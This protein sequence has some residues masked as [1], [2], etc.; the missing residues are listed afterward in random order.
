[1]KQDLQAMPDT[2]MPARA[3]R[4][5]K[6]ELLF[7]EEKFHAREIGKYEYLTDKHEFNKIILEYSNLISNS[8]ISRIEILP[9]AVLFTF[10]PL[11]IQ[12]EADGGARSAPFEILNF[13]SYEP[14][15]EAM[16]YTLIQSG[17]TILDVGAHIGWYA[18]NFAKRFPESKVYTF[19]PVGLTFEF[20]KR[21][22]ERNHLSNVVCL[23]FGLSSVEEEREFYYYKGGSALASIE[24]LISHQ[25][26]KKVKCQLKP[27]DAL[28]IELE[29]NAVNFIKCDVEGAELFMLQGARNTINEFQPIILIELYEEWCNKCG[30]SSK[31]VMDFLTS[32][33]YS[34]FQACD[35]KLHKISTTEFTNT[36]RYNYFFM[37]NKNHRNLIEKYRK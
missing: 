27:L 25:N 11:N 37:H 34:S 20:L 13:G 32:M 1:M 31:D 35:G 23:N 14:E 12:M 17:D 4:N 21:N 10:K 22:I 26:I 29:M 6:S 28:L 19:E 30:Y 3:C 16:A 36:E 33:D 8:T 24:N 9:N 2:R 7:I 15:D 5:L 18:I